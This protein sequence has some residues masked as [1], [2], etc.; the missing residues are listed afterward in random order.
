MESDGKIKDA[1]SDVRISVMNNIK[2][3]T[4]HEARAQGTSEEVAYEGGSI[5]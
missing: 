4:V 3:N 1:I 5:S 2:V